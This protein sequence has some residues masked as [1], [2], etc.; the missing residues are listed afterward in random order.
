ML[1]SRQPVHSFSFPVI[2]E[3]FTGCNI[4]SMEDDED[5]QPEFP[6]RI[7][8]YRKARRLNLVETA[9]QIEV[10]FPTLQ[11][12]ETKQPF[13]PLSRVEKLAE[14]LGVTP[15]DLLPYHPRPLDPDIAFI[16]D[17]M[18]GSDEPTRRAIVKSVKGM[19]DRDEEPFQ[20]R[21]P[22]KKR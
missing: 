19:T 2:G 10:S 11:R 9:E 16:I 5:A 15:H 4:A 18:T 8:K 17:R 22:A 1:S 3:F 7:R 20:H 21:P 12:W 6:N 14:V 13:L